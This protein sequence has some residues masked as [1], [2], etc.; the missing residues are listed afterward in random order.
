MISDPLAF[1]FPIGGQ[2]ELGYP[3]RVMNQRRRPLIYTVIG[4]AV[5]WAAAWG[6]YSYFGRVKV[7][8]EKVAAYLRS[9]DLAALSGKEREVALSKL[10]RQ[11]N[12]LTPE[13]RRQARLEG[14]WRKWFANMT[15]R[16]QSEFIEATLPSGVKQML[17]SFQDLPEEKRRQ[18]VDE[19]LRNL[20]R[21]RAQMEKD[22]MRPEEWGQDGAPELSPEVRDRMVQVGLKSFYTESS[23]QTKTELAPVLEEMQRLMERGALLRPPRRRD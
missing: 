15:E 3:L 4:L 12:A 16:E 9:V 10:I 13:Q 14:E 17:S 1:P 22:G 2:D 18:A 6:G 21:A 19:A 23:A 11:M 20:R 8:P 7:T 5:V